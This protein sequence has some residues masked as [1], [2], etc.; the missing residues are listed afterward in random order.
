MPDSIDEVERACQLFS[1]ALC[2]LPQLSEA[3]RIA[4]VAAASSWVKAAAVQAAES[5][6]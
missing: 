1:D 2:A 6:A 5:V 4:L 3:E